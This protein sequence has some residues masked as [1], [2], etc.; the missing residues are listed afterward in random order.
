MLTDDQ[1]E[2]RLSYVT[3]SDASIICGL[4]P[5]TT[6]YELWEQKTRRAVVEDIS[7]KPAVKAGIMLEGA[8]R[9][10]L[11]QEINKDILERGD[12]IIHP[13]L[14]WM[15]GNIDGKVYKENSIVE[16][17][18]TSSPEGWGDVGSNIIPRNYLLQVVHYMAVC[19]ADRCYVAVLIRGVDFRHY[20]LERDLVLEEMLIQKEKEF[21]SCVQLDIPPGPVY[22]KDLIDY[23]DEREGVVMSKKDFKEMEKIF[24]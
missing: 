11:G 12:I 17:K 19:N 14:A 20:I 10:W 22:N 2:Q 21:Y 7:H 1:K 13:K 9:D 18:T 3:G 24:K 8:I 5:Y 4:S 23:L 15:A 6:P 16:I